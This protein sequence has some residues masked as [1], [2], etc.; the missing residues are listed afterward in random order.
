[1]I[2]SFISKIGGGKLEL[3][4]EP[5]DTSTLTEEITGSID[6]LASQKNVDFIVD[7]G[8]MRR[9]AV[10]ADKLNIERFFWICFPMQSDSRQRRSCALYFA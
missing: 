1:M 3:K 2:R 10:L 7:D 6:S 9:R 4:P 5:V 8:G